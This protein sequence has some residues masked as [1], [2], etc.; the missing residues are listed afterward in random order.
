MNTQTLNLVIAFVATVILGIII[1][2]KLRKKKVGQIVRTDGPK[3][4]LKKQGTPT[5]GGIIM[6]IVLVLILGFNVLSHKILILPIVSIL[7]FGIVGFV[8][9]YKKLIKKD[10]NGL[11]P[12]KK[13]LGLFIVTAIFI[14]LYLN[15]FNLGTDII[16]PVV[17]QPFT[18]SIGAFIFFTAFILL[19]TTNALNLTDGLDGLATGVCAIIMTFFTIIAIKT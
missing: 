2:P 5:M 13:M 10:A 8:D 11:S 7:G 16:I 14:L 15:V 1:V 3:E 6:I 9:D 19:G 18:L 4:H 12:A 17:S